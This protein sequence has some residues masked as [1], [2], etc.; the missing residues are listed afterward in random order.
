MAETANG[1]VLATGLEAEHTE[2]LGNNNTL[3][4]VVWG[5]DTLEDLESLQGSGTTGGLVRNHTADGLVEDARRGAEVEGTT[6]GRV[7]TGGLAEVGMVL[8]CTQKNPLVLLFL[9]LIMCLVDFSYPSLHKM[10]PASQIDSL[11]ATAYNS[12]DFVLHADQ[13]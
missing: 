4:L 5:R 8:H 10:F 7:E 11:T 6:T 1:A 9:F 3:L 2:S 12:A 13:R